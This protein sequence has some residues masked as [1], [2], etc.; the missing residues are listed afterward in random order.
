MDAYVLSLK[1]NRFI[2]VP[3]KEKLFIINTRTVICAGSKSVPQKLIENDYK[4]RT[5]LSQ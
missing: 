5:L 1:P 2:Y 3:R 4:E